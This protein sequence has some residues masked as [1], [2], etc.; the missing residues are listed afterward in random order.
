MVV[1]FTPGVD[2][3]TEVIGDRI[4]FASQKTTE[5]IA[6]WFTYAQTKKLIR[7]AEQ[8]KG[9]ESSGT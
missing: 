3:A 8:T 7:I 4:C 1:R 9:R 2:A 5:R 6:K